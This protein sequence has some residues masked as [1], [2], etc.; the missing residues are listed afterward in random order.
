MSIERKVIPVILRSAYALVIGALVT[1]FVAFGVQ[2]FYQ[3][4]DHPDYSV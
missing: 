3:R 2:T 1:C 4:P